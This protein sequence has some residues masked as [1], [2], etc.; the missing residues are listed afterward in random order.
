MDKAHLCRQHAVDPIGECR[1]RFDMRAI[2]AV[3]DSF[4]I[5]ASPDAKR[6]GDDGANTFG[7]I[8]AAHPR[9]H[10]PNLLAVGL[11]EAA[12]AVDP[13]FAYPKPA[14]I[15]GLHGYAQ[16][17]SAGKDTPSGHWEMMGLPVTFEWRLFPPEHPSFPADLT[18]ALIKE[19]ALPG[20]LGNRHAS[21]T[22]IIEHLGVEHIRTGKPIVYTS[23]DS[24]FQIAAHE[25]HF[26]LERLYQTCKIARK[27]V[28]RYNVGRVIARPFI[29][30]KPGAFR[31][32]GNRKDYATPPHEPTLLDRHRS[33]GREVVAIGKISDIFAGRGI[34]QS[35]KADGNEEI[36]DAL[37]GATKTA[38]DHAIIFANFVDF[39]TLYGHRRD[40]GGYARALEAFDRRIPELRAQLR[41]DDLVVFTADHGCD[42]TWTG[43]DHTREYVPI[44][45]FGPRIGKGPIGRRDSFADIGQTLARHLR[46]DPLPVG[47][48]FL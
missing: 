46:L 25:T 27:L 19:A 22:E 31:R 12:R 21:G 35:I 4:G 30:E 48:S 36:F 42:P 23:G 47:T 17:R 40:V 20:V 11:G 15:N 29:G 41:P 1:E 10:I 3:L 34:S 44:L 39:D 6:F 7:H 8:F 16:E 43:S 33:R 5:G 28:D 38:P 14:E 32:T 37:I 24:V 45:A 26:G 13:A 9:L 2:V 18:E